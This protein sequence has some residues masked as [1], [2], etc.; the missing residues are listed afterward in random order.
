MRISDS[1]ASS[2]WKNVTSHSD[3]P[4]ILAL[5]TRERGE[6]G[7]CDQLGAVLC[8]CGNGLLRAW[9]S[10]LRR[11]DGPSVLGAFSTSSI[12]RHA[13]GSRFRGAHL[14]PDLLTRYHNQQIQGTRRSPSPAQA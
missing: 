13:C 3:G 12:A 5:R 4:R 1:S 6:G 7:R 2:S 8:G 10:R 9:I 11:S 14:S